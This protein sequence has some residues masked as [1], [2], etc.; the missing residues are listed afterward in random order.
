MGI[1]RTDGGRF[2]CHRNNPE[3]SNRI[4]LFR[5]SKTK[6]WEGKVI[7]M[8]RNSI[9]SEPIRTSITVCLAWQKSFDRRID[10]SSMYNSWCSIGR[11][12]NEDTRSTE[13]MYRTNSWTVKGHKTFR[14][15]AFMEPY[16]GVDFEHVQKKEIWS[17]SRI[18]KRP[19][20]VVVVATVESPPIHFWS[21]R[22]T[23]RDQLKLVTPE[24]TSILLSLCY[25]MYI[26]RLDIFQVRATVVSIESTLYTETHDCN[27]SVDHSD[28]IFPTFE[29]T[30]IKHRASKYGY[31]KE[32]REPNGGWSCKC[33]TGPKIP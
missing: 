31:T 8:S 15:Q 2:Q 11:R 25:R 23:T 33:K 30:W 10:S 5:L 18:S 17:N 21:S 12:W 26:W 13:L 24:I 1:K 20:V 7:G 32:S 29:W 16:T 28:A 3:D 6:I 14:S 22:P 19:S 27:R 9:L 4:V